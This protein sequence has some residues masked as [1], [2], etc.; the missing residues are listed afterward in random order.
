M[1]RIVNYNERNSEDGSSFFALEI[2]RGLEV[3]PEFFII[4]IFGVI[5]LLII[6]LITELTI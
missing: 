3:E 5:C 1:V 4:P 6:V 2:Q